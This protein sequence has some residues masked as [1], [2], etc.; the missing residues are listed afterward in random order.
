MME[1]LYG[2]DGVVDPLNGHRL[3]R[4]RSDSKDFSSGAR[5]W[6]PENL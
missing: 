1:K 3:T 2:P 4:R 5:F 6:G